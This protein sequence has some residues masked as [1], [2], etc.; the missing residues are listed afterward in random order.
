MNKGLLFILFLLFSILG[1]S[2][3][4][5]GLITD[6]E[7]N[8]LPAV[9][10]SVLGKNIGVIS[11]TDGLYS[12]TIPA[13][14]SVVIGY[15]FIGYHIEKIR[16]PMLKKGQTYTLNIQL[17]SVS[18]LL[19]DVIVT[20]QK[21]R[22][23]SFSRIKPKHV[24]VLP[25]NSG[26]IEAILK[27]L[28]GV[29]SANELSSQYSVRGGNFDENLVYV[30]GIEVYRPF[31]VRS[32]QQ[33]GLSFV[34]TDMVGS[35]LFSAGG[36]AAKYGDKMSSVLDIT[37]KR[38]KET[39]ASLQLSMLG[40]SG[41][42]EG[43]NGR[44]SYLIGARHKTS[45]Y[46]FNAMDTKADYTPKFSDLQAFINYELNTNWQISFLGNISKNEYTMVP[47]NRDTDFGTINEALKLRIYFE[48]QE[49]DKY[50]TYF[51]ALSTTYQPSIE[52]NLQFTTSAFQTFE[53]ESFD[54]LGEYWLYQLENN[55]DS[56]EFG[57]VA[58]DRGVGKY[59]N[60]ARNS[61]SARVLNFL[62][63]G[64]YNKN[65]MK[66]DWGFRIQK[67]E[68]EDK[69][70][71]WNLIDSAFFNFPHPNDSI[72]LPSNPNQQIVMSKLLKT[73]INLSSYR[74]SGYMQVSKDI[75][76]LTLNAGTRG[77][78]WTYNEELL[79]SP[80]T[81]LS[82][83]P[84]WEKDVVFRAA[85]GI[86]YQ[87]PFY[88]ELRTPEGTLNHNIKA[89]K[90]THYVLGTDYLFYKW[91]RPFKWIT[92]VY[93]KNLE[94]LIP[95]KVDNVH[96][97]YLANDLSNG[98]ATGIDI[99]LNGEFVP[100]VESWAS[101]SVMKT[102]EDI[103]G[104]TKIDANGNTVE[105][106]YI[107][108]P[109]DQRVNFSMF[110]QDYIPGKPKY[111]MHL[112]LIY[113]TGLPF[114]PPNGE[115]HQDILRIPNYR[116]VDIGFSAV[117]KAADKK[118]KLEWLNTFNS[119]W[120]SAEVFNLLDINNTISYLWVADVSGREYAVPNYLTARQLNAKLIF[121]F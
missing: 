17:K 30:N 34:N 68:I 5:S 23:E 3:T 117:L 12:L 36:F 66:V 24:S 63:R 58:F 50:E 11:E 81:S 99:K 65:A 93:Y 120:L 98:Y 92:E 109:T 115:K 27:T 119:V 74:N 37:Y 69:I 43:A 20:D 105:A 38:P 112:N 42:I 89:Q 29:S 71:E 59:I 85:T 96:I 6:E 79:L 26:G 84:I 52:L 40:G 75:G 101:L 82:Y 95:Y 51:G 107:A 8:I 76:N 110:F 62:H 41:Y 113:G 19:G 15:S 121:T 77:G 64:N 46:L 16:I 49:V 44:L 45:K 28:P 7:D 100:G 73:Q 4:I 111:K 47:K 106:G 10:I 78:Y 18:I 118:S 56:D 114:G 94:N 86:Y 21:S 31:L 2:Q 32:G 87:S 102:A 90:S 72:G 97:Q 67:E 39:A 108:R 54:I 103:V 13:N 33:E 1:Y 104:D 48:G 57:D 9:N 55:L 22:K 25:G 35:I 60:H 116:R 61:L 80:R 70:S 88:R 91:G 83:A 14:R 53:Q